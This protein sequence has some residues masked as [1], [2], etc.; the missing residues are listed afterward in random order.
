VSPATD[1]ADRLGGF[2]AAEGCFTGAGA[3]RFRFAVGLGATD[4]T[5]CEQLRDFLGVGYIHRSPRRKA[6]YDDEVALAV[7]SLAELVNVVVP[8]MDEHLPPSHKRDQYEAWRARLLEYWDQRAK[9]PRACTAEGC[10]EVRRA[11]G[12]CR[13]HYYEA[14]GC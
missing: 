3:R 10:T 9:R 7:T 5:M 12:L 11:K 4:A 6:H 8:F 2:V 14:F 1:I 13:R